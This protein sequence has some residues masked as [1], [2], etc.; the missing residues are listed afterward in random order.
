MPYLMVA[1]AAME[2]KIS[3]QV[4][5]ISHEVKAFQSESITTLPIL[6]ISKEY[7]KNFQIVICIMRY[8]KSKSIVNCGLRAFIKSQEKSIDVVY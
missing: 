8:T 6:Q 3:Y 4:N 1:L 7:H 5:L 2:L